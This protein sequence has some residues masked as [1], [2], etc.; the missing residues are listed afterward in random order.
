MN[1]L[2]FAQK[3][4]I[5]FQFVVDSL[6]PNSPYGL[7][8]V[9][10]LKP[11]SPREKPELLRQ[12]NN[13]QRVLEGEAVCG[14]QLERMCRI[15]MTLK[16]IRNTIHKCNE[17]TLN[18]IEL[19]EVKRF[20]IKSFEIYPLWVEV[21]KILRLEGIEIADTTAALDLLDPGRNRLASFYI[22]DDYSPDLRT[23]RKE[24]RMLEEQIRRAT[25]DWQKKDLLSSRTLVA[26]QEEQE[27][28][29]ICQEL[30]RS[31]RPHLSLILQNMDAIGEL[32][33][34]IEKAHLA[35]KYG[36]V[37]PDISEESLVLR[38]MINP[39]IHDA[40]RSRGSGFTPVTISLEK[41]STVI[42]GANM[43]GKSVALKTLALNILL[44]QCGMFPFAG[45]AKVPLFENIFI[46]SEDQESVDRGLSSF[47]GEIVQFNQM[48]ENMGQELSLVILDEFARGT[49]PDEGTA[50]VQ[51]VT[52][53]LD[54]RN[55]M[56][57]LATHFD[58]VSQKASAH[59]QVI[60]LRD[61]DVERLR[62]EIAAAGNEAGVALIARHMNYGLYRV[63]EDQECPRD[64]LNICRLLGTDAVILKMM[65]KNCTNSLKT[66]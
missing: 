19:F 17:A 25:E 2:S 22:A 21:Q 23:L 44:V 26:A 3:E 13:I 35:R 27:E 9:R 64:A 47:G 15:F 42:T 1:E 62:Q 5:G 31:L 59:Y 30:S 52:E 50:I 41:G 40:L 34:T 38:D 33:V 65:E 8:L 24:K 6:H 16:M 36:A 58:H 54:S 29:R 32:D 7:E 51:A 28:L 45:Y 18:E 20:L 10:G 49:N 57:V 4:N 56:A 63:E 55:A 61:L 12:L 60:G 53:Y 14:G 66:D 48:I 39:Q 46:I 43:G 11:L 37:M